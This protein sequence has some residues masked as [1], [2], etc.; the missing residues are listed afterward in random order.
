VFLQYVC[1][2]VQGIASL[3]FSFTMQKTCSLG[4]RCLRA[5]V[6]GY[7]LHKACWECRGDAW[8]TVWQSCRAEGERI[9]LESQYKPMVLMKIAISCAASGLVLHHPIGLCKVRGKGCV[10]DWTAKNCLHF[11][12]KK[13]KIVL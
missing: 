4:L 10:G 11:N 5:I 8:S 7:S 1:A 3:C 9:A 12:L 13:F 6:P 2:V